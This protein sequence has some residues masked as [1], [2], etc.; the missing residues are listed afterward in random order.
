MIIEGAERFGLAQLHQIR[1]RVGRGDK[2]SSCTLVFSEKLSAV[3][4]ERLKKLRNCE[5]GFEIAEFDL[6]L[7]GE[8][9]VVGARQSG[10]PKF[11]IGDPFVD[12]DILKLARI[13]A[14]RLLNE[15]PFLESN[16]GN[17]VIY[18]LNLMEKINIF[19]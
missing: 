8:G 10:M 15:D 14:E 12:N 17:N 5:D 2:D 7:R 18:L 1:G 11:K 3:A 9:E 4:M 16:R 13:E 6:T 19:Y